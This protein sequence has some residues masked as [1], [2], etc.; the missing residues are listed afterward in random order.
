MLPAVAAACTSPTTRPVV[1]SEGS[2]S[3]TSI[4]V[5]MPEHDGRHEEHEPR[6][7]QHLED[8]GPRRGRRE[9]VHVAGEEQDQRGGSP[10]RRR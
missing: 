8:R 2:D 1:S 6:D 3:F 4:G 9:R 5:G 10:R 7:P